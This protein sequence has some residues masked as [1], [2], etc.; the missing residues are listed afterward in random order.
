MTN[1]YNNSKNNNNK[2]YGENNDLAIRSRY[3][4]L[5]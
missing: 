4:H 5:H 3:Q 1:S 2:T